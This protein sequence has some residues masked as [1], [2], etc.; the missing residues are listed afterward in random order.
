MSKNFR[1]REINRRENL[2]QCQEHKTAL[3]DTIS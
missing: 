1:K 2:K 3:P